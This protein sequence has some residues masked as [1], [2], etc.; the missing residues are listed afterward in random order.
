MIDALRRDA[1]PRG[2][3]RARRELEAAREELRR[4]LGAE[5]S[6]AD[7]AARVGSDENAARPDDRPHQHD[8]IDVAAVSRRQRRRARRCRR[9][10]CRPSRTRPIAPTKQHEVR[11]RVRAA[12]ATLPP[13]ERKVIGLYYYGEV[14]MKQ[15]GAEIGVNESR[16]S[17]LHARAIQRLRE[18]LGADVPRPT[19]RSAPALQSFAGAR[20][21]AADGRGGDAGAPGERR[22][23][24]SPSRS[25]RD[26]AGARRVASGAATSGVHSRQRLAR[27]AQQ[28]AAAGTASASQRQPVSS[29]KRSASVPATSPVTKMHAARQ[30]RRW[31]RASRGRTS[32]RRRAA[33]SGRRRS[34]R[35]RAR[36]ARASAS[37]P[38]PARSTAKPASAE[39]LGHGRAERRL[40]LDD[41]HR[42]AA[43]TSRPASVAP[44]RAAARASAAAPPT[45]SST[46]NDAPVPGSDFTRDPAAVLLHDRVGHRQAEARALADLLRR[47]ERIEDPSAA[48][49]PARRARRR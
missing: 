24:A 10:S 11:D 26:R 43:P 35:R 33:S 23:A 44:A 18:A 7:L 27:G 20:C 42:G 32:C 13:R 37:S 15:I 8:R 12:I 22:V 30:R 19:T 5:P 36:A 34:G 16:V 38:S 9:C 17:Q 41:Q 3:R 39:R 29:R 1:W 28:V 21:E 45:G 14:T 2:V 46:K 6:L 47:E 31:P 40:V 4:E 48:R 49:P 25:G